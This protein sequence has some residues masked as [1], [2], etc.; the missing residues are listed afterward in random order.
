MPKARTELQ[1]TTS[2]IVNNKSNSNEN[3][4]ITSSIS[5]SHTH[6]HEHEHIYIISLVAC[7]KRVRLLKCVEDRKFSAS[8][9]W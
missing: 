2:L 4:H 7:L 1:K 6:T 8:F 3:A 5:L 9:L